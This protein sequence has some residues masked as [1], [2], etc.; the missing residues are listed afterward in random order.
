MKGGSL[1][2][3]KDEKFRLH[4]DV[5]YPLSC[6]IRDFQTKCMVET[7]NVTQALRAI[8]YVEVWFKLDLASRTLG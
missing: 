1:F 7:G 4:S 8:S 3:Q 5:I 2:S 6:T